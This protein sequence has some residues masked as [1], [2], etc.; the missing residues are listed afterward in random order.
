MKSASVGFQCPDCV[1]EGAATIRTPRAVYGGKAHDRPDVTYALIGIN[2]LVFILTTA[3]G[4]GLLSGSRPSGL[5]QDLAMQPLLIAV[6]GDYYRLLT[7]TF[8]H[9][10]LVHIALNMYC[11]YLLG[12]TLERSLGRL[13][14]SALYLIS[15]LAGSAL[16]YSSGSTFKLAAGASGAVFG[17]FAAFYVL[18]RK[19]GEDTSQIA[20]TILI[21]LVLSFTLTFIDW[22]GHVGGMIG[23]ALVAMALVYAPVGK[24]RWVYQAAGCF[25]VLAVVAGVVGWRTNAVRDA[26]LQAPVSVPQAGEPCPHCGDP[27]GRTTRLSSRWSAPLRGQGEPHDDEPE[28]HE[29]VAV[30]P[31]ADVGHVRAHQVERDQP[32]DPD[33][34]HRQHQRSQPHRAGA[35]LLR[36]PH[37]RR[38]RVDGLLPLLGHGHVRTSW[39]LCHASS[40]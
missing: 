37:R 22:R 11:L 10:G 16:S 30:A 8:L 23:G 38:G 26:P 13:R 39:L 29:Q 15:G 21:N 33:E 40:R 35:L 2:A 28:A 32:G 25:A 6:E 1:K 12:P 4:T 18:T 5:F 24:Q 20:T 34:E 17:L 9:F 7:A 3:T 19:R 14:F 27:L 31:R 36:A